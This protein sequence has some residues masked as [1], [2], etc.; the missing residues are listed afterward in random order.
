MEFS[1]EADLSL[2]SLV[3]QAADEFRERQKQGERPSVEEYAA[4]YPQAASLLRK[5]LAALDFLGTSLAAPLGGAAPADEPVL[6]TLGDFRVLCEVG[7]GG[8]GVVYEAEQM[9]LGRRVALKVL[10]FASTMDPR[11]L[12]RFQNEAR[13]AASLE[14]PHIVPV[15]GVGCERGVHYYAMKF[16]DGQSLAELI[17]GYDPASRSRPSTPPSGADTQPAAAAPTLA[18]PCD[19]AYFRRVAEWGIQA[20]EALEYAHGLGIV[21]RDVKPG[22]LMIDGQGKLWITDFGLARTAADTGLTKTGDVLGTLRYMSPEQ[23]LAR[24]GLV[25]H[26]TDVY[27]LGA[28]LYELLTGR[29]AVQG[30]DRQEILRRIADE[31]PRPPRVLGP[32]I[33]ADLETV[34]LKALAKEPGERYGTA[35]ELADDLGRFLRQEPVRARRASLVQRAA[36]WGKRHRAAVRAGFVALLAVLVALA[37]SLAALWTSREQ[38]R[39]ALAKEQAALDAETRAHAAEANR[40]RQAMQVVEDLYEQ[41]GEGWVFQPYLMEVQR[42]FLLKALRIYQE[43]SQSEGSDPSARRDRARASFRAG[44][45][46]SRLDSREEAE[47]ALRRAIEIQDTLVQEFP[48]ALAYR[49]DLARSQHQLGVVL[50][51][52]TR[53]K[54]AEVALRQAVSLGSRLVAESRDPDYRRDLA[55]YY[56]NL[57]GLLMHTN[58]SSAVE[59]ARRSL[60]LYG[61]LPKEISGS[62]NCRVGLSSALSNLGTLLREAGQPKDAEAAFRQ[63]L[64]VREGLAK[65]FPLDPE[66]HHQL[67]GILNNFALLWMKQARHLPEARAMLERAVRCQQTALQVRPAHPRYR[68]FLATHLD[69]LTVTLLMLK[70]HAAAGH[71]TEEFARLG[72]EGWD[73]PHRAALVL[74]TCVSLAE[75]DDVLDARQRRAVTQGYGDRAKRWLRQAVRRADYPL[76]HQKQMAWLLATSEHS[77]LRDP[78]LGLEL[79]EN[80]VKQAQKDAN[81]LST[82]GAAHY[83]AGNWAG[84]VQALDQARKLRK[85]SYCSDSFFWSMALWRLGRVEDARRRFQAAA[86]FM[87][88]QAPRD[89]ELRRFRAE[90]TALLKLE[91]TNAKPE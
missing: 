70:D 23:A 19:A 1:V 83:R 59:A 44:L 56:L 14:H 36:K 3:A 71:A 88:Q 7:R 45:I 51:R 60:E 50:D 9:S 31:E 34:V 26:R 24:H 16:I 76:E 22:N 40:R 38:I 73:R 18:A 80:V 8:M 48:S 20:A 25:D 63:A 65:E 84:A 81:A 5:V 87:D 90:A 11:H 15:F 78:A 41:L 67:G 49:Q 10:P 39:E 27:S 47:Q 61:Q 6:G 13:A 46:Q 72:P 42:G 17:V 33:P 91:G 35:Q 37:V 64:E 79:A 69:N 2:E 66:Q 53:P 12:Q 62:T 55:V 89:A 4:R 82:L 32:A 43:L 57:S 74:I 28:T 68:E 54:E 29:P 85:A 58:R 86:R 52:A 77:C 30:Q 75:S 21:H